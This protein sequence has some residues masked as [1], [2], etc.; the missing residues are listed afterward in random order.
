MSLADGV[1]LKEKLNGAVWVAKPLFCHALE[2][3]LQLG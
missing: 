1:A 2:L 3:V